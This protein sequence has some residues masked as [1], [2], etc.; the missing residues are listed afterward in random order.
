MKTLIVTVLLALLSRAALADDDRRMR[1]EMVPDECMPFWLISGGPDSPMAWNQALS[2]GAC[3][4]DA[5]VE[6]ISRLDELAGLAD[7]LQDALDPALHIYSQMLV[8]GPG[9]VKLRAAFQI[10]MAE[11]SLMTRARSSIVPPADLATSSAAMTRYGKL[12]EALEGQL[13]EQARLAWIAFTIVERAAADD[14]AMAP[15]EVT[16]NMVRAARVMA[17]QLAKSWS[18]DDADADASESFVKTSRP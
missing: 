11:V 17:R 14:P 12:H 4:Q 16:R 13:R 7:R 9:P 3:I 2:F 5:S 18:F 6:R 10:G 15:D 8:R 1:Y